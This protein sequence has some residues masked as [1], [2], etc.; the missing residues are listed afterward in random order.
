[1][2]RHESPA[3]PSITTTTTQDDE[4]AATEQ[5]QTEAQTAT[6][7]DDDDDGSNARGSARRRIGE[8]PD[9]NE[10]SLSK[11]DHVLLTRTVGSSCSRRRV[12]TI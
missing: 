10:P 1:M 11:A 6:P 4:L 7:S 2:T 8:T 12:G 3:N 5:T 9:D